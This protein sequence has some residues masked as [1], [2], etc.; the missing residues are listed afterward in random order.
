MVALSLLAAACGTSESDRP[1]DQEWLARW[2]ERRAL[3][4]DA[5]MILSG[6]QDL[7]DSLVGDLRVS[8]PDL[9]PSPADA[10]DPVVRDWSDQAVSLAF[11]CPDEPSVLAER[12]GSL[13]LLEA[14]I[15]AGLEAD[16]NG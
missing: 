8:L 1:T 14:E 13:K 16:Q 5:E 15:N 10:L 2:E 7:C 3:V 4:P 6:G 9:L 12:L 11:D